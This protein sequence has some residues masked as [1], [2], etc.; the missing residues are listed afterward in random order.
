MSGSEKKIFLASAFIIVGRMGLFT[1]ACLILVAL[2]L[3]YPI[4][5]IGLF[6]AIPLSL[7]LFL[8][9]GCLL[10]VYSWI[11]DILVQ[12]IAFAFL[13]LDAVIVR[14]YLGRDPHSI[15]SHEIVVAAAS[16]VGFVLS[17]YW[18]RHRKRRGKRGKT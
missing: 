16:I 9:A 17:I 18:L 4:Q 3:S 5:S 14:F 15:L 10:G 1:S 7:L 2:A 8:V 11:I 13:V 12:S 6:I